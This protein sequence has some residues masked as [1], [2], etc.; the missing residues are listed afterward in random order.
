VDAIARP[1]CC[2]LYDAKGNLRCLPVLLDKN[3]QDIPSILGGYT[4]F[5]LDAFGLE[6][7][8][9]SYSKLYR[10]L[11]RQASTSTTEVGVLQ[12]LPIRTLN[13]R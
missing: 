4:R 5:E 1:K 9:S 3:A 10:L 7:A 13:F 8:Q 6:N 2:Y 12:K 11:T